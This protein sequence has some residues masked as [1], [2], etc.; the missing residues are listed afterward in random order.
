MAETKY[1]KLPKSSQETMYRKKGTIEKSAQRWA[2]ATSLAPAKE[3]S[4]KRL[5][6]VQEEVVE[7][8]AAVSSARNMILK[9]FGERT[10]SEIISSIIA[11]TPNDL[12]AAKARISDIA[13]KILKNLNMMRKAI[14]VLKLDISKIPLQIIKGKEFGMLK[15]GTLSTLKEGYERAFAAVNAYIAY[16][17]FVS[18]NSQLPGFFKFGLNKYNNQ[19]ISFAINTIFVAEEKTAQDLYKGLDILYKELMGAK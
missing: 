2:R 6:A 7:E 1:A 14:S 12:A 15:G 5:K 4:S 3:E 17:E 9:Q 8:R 19:K 16:W 10:P 13:D 11:A 18:Q